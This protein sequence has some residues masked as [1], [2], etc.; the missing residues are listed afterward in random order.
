MYVRF[1]VSAF[2][3]IILFGGLLAPTL[4]VKLGLGGEL[5]R[6][7]VGVKHFCIP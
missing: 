6:C 2:G 3:L 5:L 1:Y 7:D 4:E